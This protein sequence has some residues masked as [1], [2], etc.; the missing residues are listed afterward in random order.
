M[1]GLIFR[2]PTTAMIAVALLFLCAT[3]L[4]FGAPGLQV[5]YLVPIALVL[6]VIRTRTVVDAEHVHI[7]TLFGAR[8]ISW[9]DITSLRLTKRQGVK[10]VLADS[11]EV[12]LPAVRVRD[13]AALSEASGGRFGAPTTDE[14]R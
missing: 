6:W 10:V 13:L 1:S 12:A 3:P 4:A 7:R 2:I 8:S 14:P 11:S 5:I 9:S